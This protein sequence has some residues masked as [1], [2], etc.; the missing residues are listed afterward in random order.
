MK[1]L[2]AFTMPD[3]HTLVRDFEM[4]R[5]EFKK[6]YEL[7]VSYLQQVGLPMEWIEIAMRAQKDFFEEN[8]EWYI[9]LSRMVGKPILIEVFEERYAYFITKFE[10]NFVD[11]LGKATTLST[12]QIDVENAERYD[13]SYVDEKGEKKRPLILHASISGA[14]E[15]VLYALLEKAAIEMEQ[16]KKASL[17]L[18]LSPVQV[19]II[20][21][22]KEHVEKAIEM[23]KTFRTARVDVDDM[24]ES[25]SR[26]IRRAQKEW[27]PYVAV[28]GEEEVKG[29]YLTVSV[30]ETGER[31]KITPEELD[32]VIGEKTKGFPKE[33]LTMPM[34]LSKRPVFRVRQ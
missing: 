5:E 14:I 24:E 33:R 6:Q 10:F 31:I 30:R 4:A 11:Y 8:R 25:L 18:W 13:I 7:A 22:G 2:R 21:V 29:G 20:P 15:R 9:S 19:R 34:L 16:G 1:R 3:M 26:R 23:A 27:I 12:V 32:R 17:P 28:V